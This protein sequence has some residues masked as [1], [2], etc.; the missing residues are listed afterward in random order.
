M[1]QSEWFIVILKILFNNTNI[2]T[3][4][5]LKT[6]M[7]GEAKASDKKKN[8]TWEICPYPRKTNLK[9]WDNLLL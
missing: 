5:S 4:T 1:K 3:K 8:K 7:A 9:V 2:P 6:K